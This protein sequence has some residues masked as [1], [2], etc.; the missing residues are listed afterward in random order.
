[1]SLHR[2]VPEGL[3][4]GDRAEDYT[5]YSELLKRCRVED[6]RRHV[7]EMQLKLYR[8]RIVCNCW[9]LSDEESDAMWKIYGTGMGVMLVST[10]GR[11]ASS[12]K[13]AYSMIFCSPNP[14]HYTIAPVRYVEERELAELPDFYVEHPW[15]LKR[16]SF[17]HEQ[18]IRVSHQLP[19][20][21][22]AWNGGMLIEVD[23]EKLIW[24]IVPSPFN[25]RW[26]N[27]PLGSAIQ[28]LLDARKLKIQLRMSD[29]M[30]AP[31]SS[32]TILS[33]LQ[34]FKFKDQTGGKIDKNR[35]WRSKKMHPSIAAKPS[36]EAKA[37]GRDGKL[38]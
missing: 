10:I 34:M 36:K 22:E 11:L 23:A 17:A 38:K 3:L 12:I 27:R 16:K 15:L 13:G 25:S 24:E 7:S 14:Q 20:V 26:A 9:H 29:H 5:R 4:T 6:L 30:A 37:K 32:S 28:T 33:G 19:W 35:R 21:I 8:S 1:M 2:F 18:E 31:G